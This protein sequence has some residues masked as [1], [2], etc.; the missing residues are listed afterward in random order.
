MLTGMKAFMFF[1]EIFRRECFLAFLALKSLRALP[2]ASLGRRGRLVEARWRVGSR[3]Q[4]TVR[5]LQCEI[6]GLDGTLI[7]LTVG[8][9]SYQSFLCFQIIRDVYLP[10]ILV[11]KL[12]VRHSDVN[13]QSTWRES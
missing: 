1:Q 5:I 13:L 10:L 8:R 4:W 7:E 6:L 11:L 12:H 9:G 2:F 3:R